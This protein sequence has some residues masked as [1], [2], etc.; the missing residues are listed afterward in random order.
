MQ[1]ALT[2]KWSF[3]R[4]TLDQEGNIPLDH[5]HA[6]L[7]DFNFTMQ[8]D[9]IPAYIQDGADFISAY[10]TCFENGKILVR[11]ASK[12]DILTAFSSLTRS[13]WM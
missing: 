9:R 4:G 11:V 13:T 1:T 2:E 10:Y 12:D 7:D 6:F 5:A 8:D 3:D